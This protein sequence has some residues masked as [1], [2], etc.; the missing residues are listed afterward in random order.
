MLRQKS[1]QPFDIKQM[2]AKVQ[3]ITDIGDRIFQRV[4][5]QQHAAVGKPDHRGVIAVDI[6]LDQ[7]NRQPTDLQVQHTLEDPCR[8]DQGRD[9]GHPAQRS[10]LDR[11]VVPRQMLEGA[12]IGDDL[13]IGKGSGSGHMVKVAMAEHDRDLPHARVFQGPADQPGMGQ[14]DM[15]VIDQ[16]RIIADQRIRGDAQ[17]Q[18]AVIDPVRAIGKALALDPSV[19]EGEQAGMRLHD[20][21]MGRQVGHATAIVWRTSSSRRFASEPWIFWMSS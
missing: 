16:R 21:D 12:A 3:R 4:T 2:H 14:R 6:G 11:C 13:A 20:P 8:Q 15:G 9:G 17:R 18:C 7:P 1:G 5:R 19:I 10:R